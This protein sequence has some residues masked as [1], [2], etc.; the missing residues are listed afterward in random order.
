MSYPPD[1]PSLEAL[2]SA[3]F[4][5][6]GPNK[7]QE[8]AR[9]IFEIASRDNQLIAHVL[10]S[11]PSECTTFPM[12]KTH[13]ERR[14]YP[15]ATARGVPLH[16]SYAAVD[17]DATSACDTSRPMIIRPQNIFIEQDAINDPLAKQLR[18]FFPDTPVH[19]ITRYKDAVKGI[20]CGAAE[21]NRRTASFYVV[22]ERYDFFK[23]C[24]CTPGVVSCGY[25]NVNLG[26][27]CPF[28]CSYCFLQNYTNAPG[29]IFPSNIN[30]FFSAFKIYASRGMRLGSGET[31]DSLAFD[32]ITGFSPQIVEFFR[33]YP[34]TSFEFKTKSN[35]VAG[36]LSVKSASNIVAAWSVNPQAVI[37]REEY[38]TAS[39]SQRLDAARRCA[40]AGYRTGFHFDP[41]FHYPGWQDDYS[42]VVRD[43]FNAVPP[44]SIAWISLG[45]LRMTIRQKKMIEN[46]FPCNTILSSELL[47]APD[48]KVRYTEYIR[49]EVYRYMID[50]IHLKS[51]NVPVYLC[52][53]TADMWQ[54]LGLKINWNT[55]KSGYSNRSNAHE[56]Q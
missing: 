33:D 9:L 12:I 37:T 28:E 21:F 41:I 3:R 46:R 55:G 49:E 40:A 29:I 30:D 15:H 17:I 42:V 35:N 19:L 38:Y 26:S 32:T 47:T 51:N 23:P 7:Q 10:D 24:P 13:L 16:A 45:T 1:L 34:M 20:P 8:L 5:T 22:R 54:K 18:T 43:I 36:L 44:E 52:M 4:T 25:H 48:G 50:A 31:T 2:S 39:L 6:F 11:I 56:A 27:G 14:R 53:E